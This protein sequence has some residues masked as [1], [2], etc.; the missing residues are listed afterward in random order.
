M[1]AIVDPIRHWA[2]LAGIVARH[3]RRPAAKRPAAVSRATVLIIDDKTPIASRGAVVTIRRKDI[4]SYFVSSAS[5]RALGCVSSGQ[6]GQC[7]QGVVLIQSLF[8]K[9]A[10]VRPG[11]MRARVSVR[12]AVGVAAC[13]L[14]LAGCAQTTVRQVAQGSAPVIVGP[15]VSSNTT[16]LDPVFAC[17]R[18]S[19]RNSVGNRPVPAIA[20]SVGDVRDYSGRASINEGNAVTQGG[21]LMVISALGKLRPRV[22]VHERFDPRVGE[23]E[24]VYTDRRQLGDGRTY[25]IPDAQGDRRVPWVPY[26]GGTILSSD[27]FIVGGVTELNYTVQSGGLEA[28]VNGVGGRARSF[29][30]NVGV[31]L[32]I[33]NTRTLVVAHTVSLQKQVV[34]FE[35]GADIF[36]FFG[37]RL[38]DINIGTRNLEPMQ[39]AVR[40]ILELGVLDLVQA[41]SRVPLRSCLELGRHAGGVSIDFTGSEMPLVPPEAMAFENRDAAVVRIGEASAAGR[42]AAPMPPSGSA[43]RAVPAPASAAGHNPA[44]DRLFMGVGSVPNVPAVVPSVSPPQVVAPS[45]PVQ[46]MPPVNGGVPAPT[47]NRPNGGAAAPSSGSGDGVQGR[48]GADNT[49]GNQHADTPAR[50]IL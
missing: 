13:A 27:Y 28:G 46:T 30:L 29:T 19:L 16:P 37:S 50:R 43:A 18:D 36:R 34:G 12:T 23:L 24:L 14:V 8:A 33:V 45:A 21:S 49:D 3:G 2:A 7:R 38:F 44:L 5:D 11:G 10:A 41:V 26:L 6:H 31:D 39:L 4:R 32:R 25:V 17:Y 35:V 9:G 22:R 1:S 20:I 47:P 40:T 48:S 42:P 15:P